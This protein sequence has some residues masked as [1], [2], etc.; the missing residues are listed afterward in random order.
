MA[1]ML[2][3]AEEVTGKRE[4]PGFSRNVLQ[5]AD[6]A[7]YLR[8]LHEMVLQGCSDFEKEETLLLLI[9]ALIHP[10]PLF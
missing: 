10:R 4:L 8:P 1:V 2:D 6:I 7:C 5:D 9:S 3:L